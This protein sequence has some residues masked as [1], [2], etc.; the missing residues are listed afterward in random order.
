MPLQPVEIIL[1]G[2]PR[3]RKQLPRS[4]VPSDLH[5]KIPQRP[6]LSSADNTDTPNL[7]RITRIP[8]VIGIETVVEVILENSRCTQPAV[9]VIPVI[10]PCRRIVGIVLA[11]RILIFSTLNPSEHIEMFSSIK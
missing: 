4:P 1:P 6:V 3:H 7:D 11:R 5:L 2:T 8:V 9:M 10:H